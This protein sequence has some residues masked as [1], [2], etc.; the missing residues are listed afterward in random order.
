MKKHRENK[1]RSLLLFLLAQVP[2]SSYGVVNQDGIFLSRDDLT[3]VAVVLHAMHS[4]LKASH[5]TPCSGPERELLSEIK[6]SLNAI[7]SALSIHDALICTKIFALDAL[8]S[9]HDEIF[10]SKLD[11]I[12]EAFSGEAGLLGM[13]DQELS[14]HDALTC[15]KLMA[16]EGT[17][18]DAL[19]INLVAY[20]LSIS[21][22][23]ALTAALATDD[24]KEGLNILQD[25]LET[26]LK[27]GLDI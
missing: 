20:N 2:F 24:I 14:L 3:R 7:S 23:D 18:H 8:V 26:L 16:I 22:I 9:R 10:D 5:L 4:N 25:L 6:S 1:M 12:E 17:V 21:I 13:L 15:S 27:I 19:E 11:L